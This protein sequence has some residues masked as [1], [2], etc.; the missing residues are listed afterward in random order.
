MLRQNLLQVR[1]VGVDTVDLIQAARVGHQFHPRSKYDRA[2]VVADIGCR[3]PRPEGELG[4]L[5]RRGVGEEQIVANR[6]DPL[7]P[8][9]GD[10]ATVSRHLERVDVAVHRDLDHL[11]RGTSR[12]VGGEQLRP[13]RVAEERRPG[14]GQVEGQARPATGD[15]R[16]PGIRRGPDILGR[17]SDQIDAADIRG[18]GGVA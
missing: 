6:E 16:W 4:D 14:A 11:L 3:D 2:P 10:P 17:T 13:L 9:K 12:S 1:S 7:T 18:P 5:L 8:R 15:R